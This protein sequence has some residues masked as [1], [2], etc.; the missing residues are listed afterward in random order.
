MAQQCSGEQ[1]DGKPEISNTS[2]NLEGS[3]K[4][5]LFITI[6][7]KEATYKKLSFNMGRI[8]YLLENI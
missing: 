4:G 6:F 3:P 2:K 7:C 5:P 1:N 8:Y